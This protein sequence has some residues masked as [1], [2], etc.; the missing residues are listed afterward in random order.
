MK[1]K[2]LIIAV[3]VILAAALGIYLFW[4]LKLTDHLAENDV[5]YISSTQLSWKMAVRTF[6]TIILNLKKEHS[7]ILK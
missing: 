7:H 6:Y 4:P 3:V 1:K 2:L 5:L